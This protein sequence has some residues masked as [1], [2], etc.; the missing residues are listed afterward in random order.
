[1]SVHDRH[2]MFQEMMTNKKIIQRQNETTH[3]R[4]SRKENDRLQMQQKRKQETPTKR[5]SRQAKYTF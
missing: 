5:K 2:E 1:M 4:D 3:M